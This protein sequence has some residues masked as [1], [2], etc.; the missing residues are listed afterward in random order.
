M[1]P[2]QKEIR[3]SPLPHTHTNTHTRTH[4][5]ARALS[6]SLFLSPSLSFSLSLSHT[7]A[8]TPTI[9]NRPWHYWNFLQT[10]P[11]LEKD[12]SAPHH[13]RLWELDAPAG[14][15]P[16]PTPAPDKSTCCYIY[17]FSKIFLEN[18]IPLPGSPYIYI[19]YIARERERV[20]ERDA[21][22]G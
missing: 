15:E 22:A 20:W 3:P 8:L 11:D 14:W 18:G 6:L 10:Q 12:V 1:N 4:A 5:R 2:I 19:I 16:P 17:Y 9:Q 13:T 7:P 21:P